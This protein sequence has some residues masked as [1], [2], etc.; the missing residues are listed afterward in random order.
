MLDRWEQV[1]VSGEPDWDVADL[2]RMRFE[3]APVVEPE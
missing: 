1:D 2:S 3:P